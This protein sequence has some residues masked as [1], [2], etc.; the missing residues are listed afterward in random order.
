MD[1]ERRLGALAYAQGDAAPAQTLVDE[2]LPDGPVASPGG[3]L[4]LGTLALQRLA[5]ALACDASDL[6]PACA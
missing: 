6:P 2:W 5:A 3:T 1:D 4:Y